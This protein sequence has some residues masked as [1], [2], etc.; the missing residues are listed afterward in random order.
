MANRKN[1]PILLKLHSVMLMVTLTQARRSLWTPVSVG[2]D[3]ATTALPTCRYSDS[4]LARYLAVTVLPLWFTRALSPVGRTRT[5]FVSLMI[6]IWPFKLHCIE[7]HYCCLSD[8]L[9][10][11][12]TWCAQLFVCSTFLRWIITTCLGVLI[13]F[14]CHISHYDFDGSNSQLEYGYNTTKT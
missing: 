1:Y 13:D 14:K 10:S 2:E 7:W 9:W 8:Y 11:V 3:N 4:L 6:Y 12:W 5:R